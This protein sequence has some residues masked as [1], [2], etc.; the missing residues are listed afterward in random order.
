MDSPMKPMSICLWFDDQAEE[1]AKF[2][3]QL[4]GGRVGRVAHYTGSS[5]QAAQRPVGSVMTADFTIAN[6]KV[7]GL[8]GGPLF[9]FSPAFSFFVSC[10][11]LEEM[12]SLWSQLSAGGTP[13]M[14]LD[15]YPWSEAYGWTSDKFGVEWQLILAPNSKK[16]AP[17]F[18]FT[19]TLYGKGQE[20]IDF[21]TSIFP[22]S[23]IETNVQ[24]PKTGALMHC[25]FTLNDQS[26][27]LMEGEGK[28]GHSFNESMSIVV[29]CD[30]QDEI[31]TYWSRLTAEGGMPIQCGWL[32]DKFGV[33]WQVV[34]SNIEKYASDPAKFEKVMAAVMKMVKLD[35]AAIDRAANG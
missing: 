3:T 13:R 23:K 15:K 28:H 17:S 8:N 34:P 35:M 1:A 5:A 32:K 30:T 9:K 29:S 7:L 25:A 18:L 10:S 33:S 2:Y 6:L 4:F 27:K 31:D 16:V 24:D 22:N 20:A 12:K 21:Y 11:S 26:F 14:A 19:D